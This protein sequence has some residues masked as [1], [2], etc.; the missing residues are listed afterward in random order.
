MNVLVIVLIILFFTGYKT[1]NSYQTKELSNLYRNQ[2]LYYDNNHGNKPQAVTKIVNGSKKSAI[3]IR[4][5]QNQLNSGCYN[6]L[7]ENVGK[8][9]Y[10]NQDLY[11]K[12]GQ[13]IPVYVGPQGQNLEGISQLN[14]FI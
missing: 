8:S 12:Y 9:Y 4:L 10:Q 1:G 11:S 3:I 5:S 7:L 13:P 2:C 6:Y 14:V